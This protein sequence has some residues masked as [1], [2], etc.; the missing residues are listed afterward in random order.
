[1]PKASPLKNRTVASGESNIER[2][3]TMT[4]TKCEC[5]NLDFDP[6]EGEGFDENL[7]HICGDCA[8][9]AILGAM[10]LEKHGI[11]GIRKEEK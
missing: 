1:M 7:G 11:A 5:C 9:G 2:N 8:E 10:M 6:T 3:K 4:I